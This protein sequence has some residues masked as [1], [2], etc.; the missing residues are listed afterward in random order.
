MIPVFTEEKGTK[1]CYFPLGL[2]LKV[3]CQGKLALLSFPWNSM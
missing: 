1:C 2:K 3:G